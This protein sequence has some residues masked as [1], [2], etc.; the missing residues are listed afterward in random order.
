[1]SYHIEDYQRRNEYLDSHDGYTPENEKWFNIGF[2]GKNSRTAEYDNEGNK[3]ESEIYQRNEESDY[4]RIYVKRMKKIYY[5]VHWKYGASYTEKKDLRWT[6]SDITKSDIAPNLYEAK[7]S[8]IIG[9]PVKSA[10]YLALP[11]KAENIR[12]IRGSGV[13]DC[14]AYKFLYADRYVTADEGIFAECTFNM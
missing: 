8:I 5:P 11:E 1:M 14:G 9:S 4:T 12:M 6:S 7:T 13:I 2:N 10:L 3:I